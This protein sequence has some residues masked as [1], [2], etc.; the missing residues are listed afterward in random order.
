MIV[1]AYYV[2]MSLFKS[3]GEAGFIPAPVAAWT[4]NAIFLTVG[5]ILTRRANRLG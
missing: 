1:F 2:I 3:L 4:P 5:A